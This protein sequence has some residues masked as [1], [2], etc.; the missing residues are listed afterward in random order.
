MAWVGDE[1]GARGAAARDGPPVSILAELSAPVSILGELAVLV[2][3]LD[4]LAVSVLD[5][6][7]VVDAPAHSIPAGRGVWDAGLLRVSVLDAPAVRPLPDVALDV[8]APLES[9]FRDAL[10][11][12][13]AGSL[14]LAAPG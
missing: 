12:Q 2:S 4:G 14:L 5:A 6:P 9:S 1:L 7:A 13:D 11:L 3:V 8:A 10:V